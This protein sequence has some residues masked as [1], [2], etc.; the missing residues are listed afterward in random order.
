MTPSIL[1]INLDLDY[2]YILYFI[3]L[4]NNIINYACLCYAGNGRVIFDFK[5]KNIAGEPDG[6]TIDTNG[7]L[8]VAVFNSD[9]VRFQKIIFHS[10]IINFKCV[11]LMFSK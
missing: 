11:C 8:W 6:M 5:C 1:D 3:I 7:N 2:Y 9:K 4:R 10:H